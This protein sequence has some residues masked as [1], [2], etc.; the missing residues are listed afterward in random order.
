MYADTKQITLSVF[1]EIKEHVIRF[2]CE[3]IQTAVVPLVLV[4]VEEVLDLLNADDVHLGLRHALVE[5]VLDPAVGLCPHWNIYQFV[6]ILWGQT[7]HLRIPGAE[8]LQRIYTEVCS[9]RIAGSFGGIGVD[10]CPGFKGM[11]VEDISNIHLN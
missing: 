2:I 6:V 1:I 8:L 7:P 5:D 9:W 11:E 10:S 3:E 4:P